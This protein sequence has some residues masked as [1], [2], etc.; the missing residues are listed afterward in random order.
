MPKQ[1]VLSL[2]C[3]SSIVS[4]PSWQNQAISQTT[5]MTQSASKTTTL[6]V[7][8]DDTCH[9][10]IDDEDKGQITPDISHKFTV[11]LGNHILK[12]KNDAI[13]DLVWRKV[14]DV[15]DSSQ[16]AAVVSL[17]GL[18]IQYDQAV[19]KAQN[20]KAEADTVAAKKLAEAEAEEK[21]REAAKAAIPQQLAQMLQ[22]T[23]A[24]KKESMTFYYEFGP[25]QND[26]IELL[27]SSTQ[28]KWKM[29]VTP[30]SSN[31]LVSEEGFV[32]WKTYTKKFAR[33]GAAKDAEGWME[34]DDSKM[35]SK[36]M[37]SS[38]HTEITVVNS[39]RLEMKAPGLVV[40]LTR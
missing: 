36:H 21:E 19:T 18:H 35:K 17:K 11:N 38:G 13:P 3:A 29:R 24:D 15:K 34:C 32:C 22:G 40:I 5:Q 16:A 31:R 1:M 9:F 12:C 28:L 23:W 14:V 20:Q 37:E 8:T 2:A 33:D 10:F 6:L 7:D 26:A 27:I 25:I 30:V 4:A 39:N